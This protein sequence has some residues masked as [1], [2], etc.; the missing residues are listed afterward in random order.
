M[1]DA[2][3]HDADPG[4]L[5][6]AAADGDDLQVIAALAQ[7]AVLPVSDIS[8]DSKR[9]YLALLLNRFRWEDLEEAQRDQRPYERVRSLLVL[10]DVVRVQGDGIDRQDKDL[11]LELLSIGW[12]PGEDGCGRILLQ[13]AGDGTLMVDVECVNAELRDVT[14]PYI[15]PSQRVP[16]HP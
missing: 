4:P 2:S 6:L 7:D 1:S 5:A 3:F 11:V 16:S 9:R 12:E 8:Y 14:R 10:S 15:A 13:F